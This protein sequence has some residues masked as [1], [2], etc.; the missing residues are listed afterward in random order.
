M[1]ATI[2]QASERRVCRLLSVPRSVMSQ[3]R[4][5]P[6][7]EPVVD[8]V[9]TER[10]EEL[11]GEHPTYFS[12]YITK[13]IGIGQVASPCVECDHAGVRGTFVFSCVRETTG[14]VAMGGNVTVLVGGW[15]S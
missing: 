4:R 11:I 6:Q 1:R 10:I 12:L 7:R 8:H 2:P 13:E 3:R 9:L 14:Y 15:F 5:A